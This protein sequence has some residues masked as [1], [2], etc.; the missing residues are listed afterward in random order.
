[1]PHQS[2]EPKAAAFTIP[3]LYSHMVRINHNLVFKVINA[4]ANILNCFFCY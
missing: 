4:T 1:M 2:R 3:Y